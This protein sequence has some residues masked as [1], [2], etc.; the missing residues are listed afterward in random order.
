L[1]NLTFR[2]P[3]PVFQYI[4]INQSIYD[5][6]LSVDPYVENVTYGF[7]VNA[8]WVAQQNISASAVTLFKY[9][10]SAWN[11]LPT[12]FTGNDSS[13][14]F[15]TATSNSFST[16]AVSYMSQNAFASANV[17]LTQ[18]SGFQAY[19]WAGA[20]NTVA[21]ATRPTV[22]WTLANSV[23]IAASATGIYA[24]V[25]NSVSNYASFNTVAKTGTTNV[26]VVGLSANLIVPNGK[27]YSIN[28][29]TRPTYALALNFITTT[30]NSFV[31]IVSAASNAVL[32]SGGFTTNAPSGSKTIV[33][34]VV[35]NSEWVGV[36]TLNNLVAG[37][38]G[39]NTLLIGRNG[40][41]ASAAYVF[42]AY[43]VT[44][45]DIPGSGNILT[46]GFNQIN[47]NV[48][49]VIG[50]SSINAINTPSG[51]EFAY[52]STSASSASNLII[53]NTLAANTFLTVEGNGVLTATFNALPS[54]APLANT[55]IAPNGIDAFTATSGNTITFNAFLTGGAGYITYTFKVYNSITNS[56]INSINTGT[57]N[58]F[59]FT[60]N[61]NLIGNTINANV[62][63][64]DG[65]GY[66]ANSILTGVYT[67][68]ALPSI[69]LA[70]TP[71]AP[72][73][74][75][76]FTATS[77]N[78][79]TFNA[80]VTGGTGPFSFTFRVYNSITNSLI[81]SVVTGT[82]NSFIFTTNTNLV[83]NTLNANVF[84]MDGRG[85]AANSVLVGPFTVNAVP[86]ITAFSSTPTAP[87]GIDAFT[88]TSG[89]TITFNAFV[90]GGTGPFSFTFRVYN[91]ITNSLI[92]SVVTGTTNSFVFT[93]NTNLV[94]N[95]LNANVFVT[96][97]RGNA[98]NSVL[99]GPFTVNALPSISVSTL[100]I[101]PASVISGN[102]ITFNAFITGGTGPF[103]YTFDVYNSVTNSLINSVVTG[104]TNSFV[105]TTNTNLAGN[106][107]NANVFVIDGRGNTANSVLKGPFTIYTIPPITANVPTLS[108]LTIDV[109]QI[110]VA[111][112]I[113]GGAMGSYNGGWTFITPNSVGN[114]YGGSISISLP[115]D[116]VAFNPSGTFAYVADTGS[117]YGSNGNTVLVINTISNTIVNTIMVGNYPYS[118]ALSPSATFAYVTNQYDNT[119]SVIN[120]ATN[121]VINTIGVGTTPFQ[122]AFN[123]Q[124]TFAYVADYQGGSIDVIN[125]ATNAETTS[126]ISGW[127]GTTTSAVAINPSG[128]LGYGIGLYSNL[129]DT[130]ST[131]SNTVVNSID[132][133]YNPGGMI[134]INPQG[135]LA[136]VTAQEFGDGDTVSVINLATNTIT[137][138]ITLG[139][140]QIGPAGVAFNPQGTLAYVANNNAGNVS[141]INTATNTVIA[142]ITTG[143]TPYQVAFN[144]QGTLAYAVDNYASK[145]YLLT[146][147]P[148]T[149]IAALP[150]TSNALT[151]TI[152]A[153]SSNTLS[154]TFNGV[155]QQFSAL[156]T[157][158]I[159]GTTSLYGFA[160]DGT[161]G[162]VGITGLTGTNTVTVSNTLTINSQ[163]TATALTASNSV[164]LLGQSTTFNVVI[165]GGTGPFTVNLV[166]SNGVVM[167]TV[168]WPTLTPVANVIT[169]AQITPPLGSQSY[170]VVA[171]DLGTTTPY[172]FNSVSVPFVVTLP[173][174]STS[175]TATT[176]PM[177]IGQTQTLTGAVSGGTSPVSNV[178]YVYNSTGGLVWSTMPD[179]LVVHSN[180]IMVGY[181]ALSS[182]AVARGQALL[183]AMGN[184][185]SGDSVYLRPE[186]YNVLSNSIYQDGMSGTLSNVDLYGAGKY[187]TIIT[188]NTEYGPNVF[189]GYNSVTADLS[190]YG[191]D[192]G[193][194][195]T[196]GNSILRNVFMQG[197][198]DDIYLIN[199]DPPLI[200]GDL[201]VENDTLTSGY[202]TL[203]FFGNTGNYLVVD[204]TLLPNAHTPAELA[205]NYQCLFDA[206]A[207]PGTNTII[208]NTIMIVT[209]GLCT[210]YSANGIEDISGVVNMY[211]G[212]ISVP[213]NGNSYNIYA[214][215]TVNVNSSVSYNALNVY[216]IV[217]SLGSAPYPHV[218]YPRR[219]VAPP[220]YSPLTTS[221]VQ[222]SLWGA[223]TFTANAYSVYALTNLTT[224][225]SLTYNV[226]PL[227]LTFNTLTIST[228]T[229]YTGQSQ[230]LTTYVWNGLPPYTYNILVYNSVTLVANQL[231]SNNAL[232][233]NAFSFTQNAAW[234]LGTFTVNVIVRDSNIP[235]TTVYNAPSTTY[236]VLSSTVTATLATT[237]IAP[238]GIDAFGAFSGNTITFNAFASGGSGTYSTYVFD[239]YN[240]VTNSLVNSVNTG[241]TNSLVFTTNTNLIGQTLNAN[242]F[243]TDT[244]SN[245]GN[246]V[247]VGP[248]TVNAVPSISAFT[249]FPLAPNGIDA[250]TATSGNTITFNAFE[251]GGDGPFTYVFDV[252]N[253]VTHLLVNSVNTGTTNSFVFTTNTNLIGN[254]LNANVFVTDS[255]GVTGN[256]I[257]AGPFTVNVLP[258]ITLATTPSPSS[259]TPPQTITFNAFETG[260]TGPFT[261]VFDVY[262]SVTHLLVNSVNTGTTNS[263][264]FTTNTNLVGNTLNA[265]V[266]VT[267]R[268]GNTANSILTGTFTVTSTPIC[269]ISLSTGSENF[270]NLNVNSNVPTDYGITDTDNGGGAAATILIAGGVGDSSGIWYN[271]G[272]WV[273][274]SPS[275][276]IGIT[277]T[278]Y[279]TSSQSSYIGTSI[280]N[281]L[282][283]TGLIIP[284]PSGGSTF[285]TVYLGFGVP[286]LVRRDVYTTNIVI[287]NSC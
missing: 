126:Q 199:G 66:T 230:T 118:V 23:F 17:P 44:L 224:S 144:P 25:G 243:V 133:G 112:T 9:Y 113:V 88:A 4:Q 282:S 193:V 143:G 253:S 16:Y 232:P 240:S 185:V 285:N 8:N 154:F 79:I 69:T 43:G 7:K 200:N 188:A 270:G 176:N 15:Y 120:T 208:V 24:A 231:V 142:S 202:D 146:A 70:N 136:Y 157:N 212:S 277:N 284:N 27:I 145:I 179:V 86:S 180:G 155:A 98:A 72:N 48:I 280:T 175:W 160:E 281:S 10:N 249:S 107:L 248:F 196:Y 214:G 5:T 45:N 178:I 57:T 124:G 55:P 197:E 139:P 100:P 61:T 18:T 87:A 167:N 195:A 254:T 279:S 227:P 49:Q 228:P 203:Q 233:F 46:N 181:N 77:G 64:T 221:Y 286:R 168:S 165:S 252:Y 263:F 183:N 265:N 184:V 128:T 276:V 287:E 20:A 122:V 274:T 271:N 207:Y 283:S 111:N 58:S 102:T 82:T 91:S 138:T 259:L 54:L 236:T 26:V 234:G 245:T 41:I 42:P 11:P 191:F 242:V 250:F 239:V 37:T 225:N 219:P 218:S 119:V 162:L 223:G 53:S 262:N 153:L 169:F 1:R 166:A 235:V 50:T 244:N 83:G 73:G 206:V 127:F 152:A 135:T 90:T 238:N 6:S 109:G 36:M 106:T 156:G 21:T 226:I 229:I 59:V 267:D 56:L 192:W 241:S 251:T 170:N 173:L 3:N 2:P 141:V 67:I 97:G 96:D 204:S 130:F 163:P 78:T 198:V 186:T 189:P 147:P 132:L 85:N 35:G 247:L 29:I 74:I 177:A 150:T 68:N 108:N 92:N 89:N 140:G 104:T 266:F 275:N 148:E 22:T 84:V 116:G 47:T 187:Q 158:T 52:W 205:A 210:S 260:G 278:L 172:H 256:S 33:N 123:P 222:N 76:A 272:I 261:Y 115:A 161:T 75:D 215:G 237:P 93:T 216:G 213:Q 31:V 149:P 80:F 121:A 60:T 81:N 71:I 257:L 40:V 264:V 95:T 159:Y 164:Y 51:D 103:T 131:V 101:A 269:Y 255:E 194:D 246:S 30:A 110:A 99:V 134:A 28:S 174:T 151:L 38:Y 32:A 105:F 182:N 12:S 117:Y 217:G 258:T 209:N 171:T 273:G 39:V 220:L 19:F 94:G 137:N 65:S 211:G 201:F 14:Y 62:F 190:L 268:Q 63:V 13:D 129:F 114:T 34:T 125:V